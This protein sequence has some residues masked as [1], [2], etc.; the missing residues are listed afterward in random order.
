MAPDLPLNIIAIVVSV[1]TGSCSAFH[2]VERQSAHIDASVC[3]HYSLSLPAYTKR[4]V[5]LSILEGNL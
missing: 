3:T 4:F 1:N 2:D 5:T